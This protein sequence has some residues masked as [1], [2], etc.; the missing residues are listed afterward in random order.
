MY[1]LKAASKVFPN[2]LNVGY[3]R[4]NLNNSRKTGLS[5]R[6]VELPSTEKGKL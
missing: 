5:A 4:K 2:G 1:I 3:E 6:R